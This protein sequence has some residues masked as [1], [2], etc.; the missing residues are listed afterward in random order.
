MFIRKIK[1]I[2]I[3]GATGKREDH[4]IGNIFSL[5][6]YHAINIKI[7]TNTGFFTII[8]SNK[9]IRSFKGQQVS[10]FSLDDTIQI[11]SSNLKYNINKKTLS[12]LFNGTLN[13]SNGGFFELKISHGNLIIFQTYA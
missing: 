13:E 5:V 2:R 1:D 11:E 7:F 10:I 3:I 12:D 8:N 6:K 4:T 9:K